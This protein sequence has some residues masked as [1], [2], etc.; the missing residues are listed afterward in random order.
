MDPHDI[1]VPSLASTDYPPSLPPPPMPTQP[2][3]ASAGGRYS[4]YA[5]YNGLYVPDVDELDS[6]PTQAPPRPPLPP[7]YAARYPEDLGHLV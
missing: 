5:E 1:Y 3:N 6:P 4:N 7:V 2:N